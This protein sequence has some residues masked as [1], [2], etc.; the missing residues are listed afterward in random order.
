MM[1]EKPFGRITRSDGN[2][3][4]YKLAIQTACKDMVFWAKG[5]SNM[6]RKRNAPM[7]DHEETQKLSPMGQANTEQRYMTTLGE[8]K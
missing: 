6:G 4:P 7:A 5:S 1:I 8:H 2:L 3:Q